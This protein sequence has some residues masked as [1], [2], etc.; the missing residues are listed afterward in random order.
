MK[1]KI[2]EHFLKL[3]LLS[4]EQAEEI[5]IEQKTTSPHKKFGEIALAKGYISKE[6]LEEAITEQG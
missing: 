3:D 6:D 1:E 4:F 2:G 5:L